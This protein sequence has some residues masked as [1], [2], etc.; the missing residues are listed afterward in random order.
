M[1]NRREELAAEGESLTKV[2]IQKG[3]FPGDAL[4]PLLSLIA[5]MPLN[6]IIRKCTVG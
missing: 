6:Y 2:K 1:K 3:I 5:M 4:L